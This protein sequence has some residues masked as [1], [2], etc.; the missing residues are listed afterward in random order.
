[1]NKNIISQ[2]YHQLLN[3][4]KYMRKFAEGY[5]DSKFVQEALAQLTWYHKFGSTRFWR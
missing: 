4:L 3:P 5:P 1:M 2:E